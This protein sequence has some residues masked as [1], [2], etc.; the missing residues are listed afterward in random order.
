MKVALLGLQ[1]DFDNNAGAGIQRYMFELYRKL[2]RSK[3]RDIDVEKTEI[4]KLPVI[5]TGFSFSLKTF[6]LNLNEFDIVHHLMP[7]IVSYSR[8]KILRNNIVVTTVHDF[9]YYPKFHLEYNQLQNIPLKQKVWIK[10]I[11]GPA[12]ENILLSD[13]LIANSLQTKEEAKKLGFEKNKVFTINLGIDSRFFKS[14]KDRKENK[15]FKVGYLGGA[16]LHKNLI[17]AINSMNLI[18]NDILPDLKVGVSIT[19]QRNYIASLICPVETSCFL[20]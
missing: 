15:I 3:N 11:A 9:Y 5:G 10:L 16:D 20:I 18:K 19:S 17:F 2:K 12:S 4:T 14:L 1:G 7:P 8:P 6:F 13:Y